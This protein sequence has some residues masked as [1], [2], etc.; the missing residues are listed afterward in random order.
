MILELRNC[1]CMILE[2]RFSS[3]TF[4][5]TL[6][7]FFFACF[8]WVRGKSEMKSRWFLNR[9]SCTTTAKVRS[10]PTRTLDSFGKGNGIAKQIGT[11]EVIT[12]NC[13]VGY[14]SSSWNWGALH[15]IYCRVGGG[16]GGM[17]ELK[18]APISHGRGALTNKT[19]NRLQ[20]S[21]FQVHC[22]LCIV[23]LIVA[24]SKA[25]SNRC[26]RKHKSK[27][28][29]KRTQDHH[30][31]ANKTKKKRKTN[32][33][34]AGAA[35]ALRLRRSCKCKTSRTFAAYFLAWILN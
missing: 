17:S 6:F 24:A 22:N 12:E 4:K 3:T 2:L 16:G 5:Q 8:V 34:A 11:E 30:Q 25:A 10:S 14:K 9:I 13:W 19:E 28:Q 20:K 15:R 23:K 33:D 32:K 1:C 21:L 31:S 27:K 18:L 7:F 26:N 29:N 35:A